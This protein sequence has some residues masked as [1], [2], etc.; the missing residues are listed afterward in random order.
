MQFLSHTKPHFR[1]SVTT[2]VEWL[3]YWTVQ[4]K[5][6]LSLQGFPGSS[7]GKE[8]VCSTGDPDLIPGWGRSSGEGNGN[9]LQYSCLESPTD[10]ED[11]QATVHGF[12]G[13][14]TP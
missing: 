3:P 14:D 10:R 8:S 2:H 1:G 11:W 7:V 9:L 6:F 13:L 4:I 5:T 12:A